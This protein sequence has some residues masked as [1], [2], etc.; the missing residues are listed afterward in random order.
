MCQE[1][2]D[3][4]FSGILREMNSYLMKQLL[5]KKKQFTV[6]DFL[7]KN[8]TTV[9]QYVYSIVVFMLFTVIFT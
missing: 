9:L 1:I 4:D 8:K 3:E 6:L 7:D 5:A 2:K